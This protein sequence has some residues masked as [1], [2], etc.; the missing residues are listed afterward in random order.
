MWTAMACAMLIVGN[1]V[2]WN[3]I[4]NRFADWL[5]RRKTKARDLALFSNG[6]YAVCASSPEEAMSV[7]SKLLGKS[8]E[9]LEDSVKLWS[10]VD[11]ERVLKLTRTVTASDIARVMGDKF[12]AKSH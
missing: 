4:V 8:P 12:I 6:S 1:L 2:G 9:D 5:E 3:V 7:C 11:P 10:K